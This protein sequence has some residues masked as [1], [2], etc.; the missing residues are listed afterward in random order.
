MPPISS[1][2]TSSGRYSGVAI[3]LH[4]VMALGILLLRMLPRRGLSVPAVSP[5]RASNE[6]AAAD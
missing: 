6:T 5:P 2:E 1:N 3:I 4:W